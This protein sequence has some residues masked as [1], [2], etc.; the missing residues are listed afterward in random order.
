[1]EIDEYGS[2]AMNAIDVLRAMEI[3][4][5]MYVTG[6]IS[7]AGAPAAMTIIDMANVHSRM[8]MSGIATRFA[9]IIYIGTREKLS[10]TN[11][12]VPRLAMHDTAV[13]LARRVIH[14][15]AIRH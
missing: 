4:L 13:M 7:M 6:V 3:M 11:G 2:E 12:R 8:V 15:C 1:M 14:G 9:A 5:S 10:A